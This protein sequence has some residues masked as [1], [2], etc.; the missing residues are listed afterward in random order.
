[1]EAI[2]ATIGAPFGRRVALDDGEVAIGDPVD[3][4]LIGAFAKADWRPS[5]PRG[6]AQK[7]ADLGGRAAR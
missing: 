5:E 7:P 4:L 3:Q 2:R 6:I 1:M